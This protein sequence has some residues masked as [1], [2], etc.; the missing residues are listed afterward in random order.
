MYLKEHPNHPNNEKL[1]EMMNMKGDHVLMLK[2]ALYGLKQASREWFK[3]FTK[4]LLEAGLMVCDS[5]PCLFRNKEKTLYVIIYVDDFLITAESKKL[6]N[7]IARKLSK[8]LSM[9]NLGE[10]KVFLGVQI[11]RNQAR[12]EI[13]ISQRT[14]I[15]SVITKFNLEN[16]S[17]EVPMNPSIDLRKPSEIREAK[18]RDIPYRELI[19]CLMYISVQT[20]PD[21]AYAVSKL[22]R[23]FANYDG[24]HWNAAKQVAKYLNSTKNLGLIYG[25]QSLTHVEGSCDVDWAGDKDSRKST[26][27][28]LFTFGNTAFIWKSR[29]QN[30]VA[31][32]TMEA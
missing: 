23:Y 27:G 11:E 12:K 20:R 13:R 22:A 4:L 24:S 1:Q 26:T 21:I 5:D 7:E 16:T 10:P 15:E 3:K 8:S 25:S 17:A 14:Y 28:I 9:Q 19:G 29:L 6:I 18:M 30:I 31:S 2:K 32:S